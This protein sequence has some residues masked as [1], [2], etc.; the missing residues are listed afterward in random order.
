MSFSIKRDPNR[1]NIFHEGLKRRMFIGQ[2]I[3]HPEQ[4]KYELLYDKNYTRYKAAIPMGPNLTLFRLSHFSE[5]GKLFPIFLDRLPDRDNPAYKD[6]CDSQDISVHEQN[7]II[8]L[9]TIGHRGPSSFIFES[10]YYSEFNIADI[11]NFRDELQITQ[12]DFALA[13]DISQSTLQRLESGES[14]D[15]N[16]LKRIEMLLSDPTAALW[17]LKLSGGTVH[18]AVLEKL[19][20]YFRENLSK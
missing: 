7:N 14:Q 3:Y 9:G 17:Q 12:H 13:F 4:D 6:Y 10:I 19:K 16:T 18:Y 8:L 2:L 15:I 11:K 20:N 1:L 5:K